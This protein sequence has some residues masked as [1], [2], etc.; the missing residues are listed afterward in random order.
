MKAEEV[1][2][3]LNLV[4]LALGI[5]PELFDKLARLKAQAE[6][7]EDVSLADLDT[8]LAGLRARSARIQ[9]G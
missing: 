7:G 5:A 1:A 2:T 4:I 6:S 8:L 3:V 9:A